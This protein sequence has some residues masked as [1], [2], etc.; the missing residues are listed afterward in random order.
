MNFFGVGAWEIVIVLFI[1]LL[2]VGPQRL[3]EVAVQLA[4]AVRWLRRFAGQVT[5]QLRQEFDEL[6]HEYEQLKQEVAELRQQVD[7]DTG[8][9]SQEID[10]AVQETQ[11]AVQETKAAVQETSTAVPKGLVLETSAEP[12]PDDKPSEPS[13]TP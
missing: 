4:K 9:I 7:R 5:G 12:L 13:S 6:V 8:S 2:V 10:T 11:T 1:A 3:P